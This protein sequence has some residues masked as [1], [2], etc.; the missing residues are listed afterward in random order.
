MVSNAPRRV[1]QQKKGSE[2]AVRHD[3]ETNRVEPSGIVHQVVR[4]SPLSSAK[5]TSPK[6]VPSP[7]SMTK[8]SSVSPSEKLPSRK[9][10]PTTSSINLVVDV[11]AAPT[12]A[13]ADDDDDDVSD[14]SSSD[15]SDSDNSSSSSSSSDSDSSDKASVCSLSSPC[16]VDVDAA[17]SD[18]QTIHTPGQ[19]PGRN[20]PP[21]ASCPAMPLVE[22]RS[23]QDAQET[24]AKSSTAS[25]ECSRPGSRIPTITEFREKRELEFLLG[26]T[27]P[28]V[29]EKSNAPPVRSR[30]ELQ[31]GCN[32]TPEAMRGSDKTVSENPVRNSTAPPPFVPLQAA[33]KSTLPTPDVRQTKRASES[34][35]HCSTQSTRTMSF[36]ESLAKLEQNNAYEFFFV[37]P[38]QPNLKRSAESQPSSQPAKR[39]K[40]SA[41]CSDVSVSGNKPPAIINAPSA[42]H[43]RGQ[44]RQPTKSDQQPTGQRRHAPAAHP[45]VRRRLPL[46]ED[47]KNTNSFRTNHKFQSECNASSCSKGWQRDNKS[48]QENARAMR[49]GGCNTRQSESNAWRDSRAGANSSDLL[50][51]RCREYFEHKLSDSYLRSDHHFKKYVISNERQGGCSI[52]QVLTS[53]PCFKD[54]ACEL[55]FSLAYDNQVKNFVVSS[56][57]SS[58]TLHA[59][60]SGKNVSGDA[61]Q[62]LRKCFCFL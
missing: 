27:S 4:G 33:A 13:T 5:K 3:L 36:G 60:F 20:F 11:A 47:R 32:N 8:Q 29:P 54:L 62:S 44:K 58:K 35:G 30:D 53:I 37:Q 25:A 12:I 1:L 49:H 59:Y 38:F 17:K 26:K 7:G 56:L 31:H 24:A 41:S 51:R 16:P 18:Q 21:E 19:K 40:P 14:E 34:D 39:P 23:S 28:A 57:Q 9:V 48:Q 6:T 50:A 52:L 43:Y 45:Q 2:H 61:V 22:G 10:T 46:S 15:S 42:A 55:R